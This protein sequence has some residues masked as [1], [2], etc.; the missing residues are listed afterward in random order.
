MLQ[1]KKKKSVQIKDPESSDDEDMFGKGSNS[2]KSS[3]MSRV[4]E[5]MEKPPP[6]KVSLLSIVVKFTEFALVNSDLSQVGIRYKP[7]Y[8]AE[9][10]R[11]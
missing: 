9:H 4:Q 6:V 11:I 3:L 7:W 8:M 10:A 5:I 2:Q 1:L